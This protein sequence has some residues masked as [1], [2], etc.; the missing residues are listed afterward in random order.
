MKKGGPVL[1]VL[2]FFFANHYSGKTT[3]SGI[4]FCLDCSSPNKKYIG[5]HYSS[6]PLVFNRYTQGKRRQK[7]AILV[8]V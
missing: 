3:I 4:F 7:I 8:F 1:Q 5:E 6:N 2:P